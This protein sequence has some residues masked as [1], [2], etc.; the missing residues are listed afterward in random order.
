M[1]LLGEREHGR[2]VRWGSATTA[3]FLVVASL[4]QS[5]RCSQHVNH[6]QHGFGAGIA[7]VHGTVG[8]GDSELDGGAA[9]ARK[10]ARGV[11]DSGTP[12]GGMRAARHGSAVVGSLTHRVERG[13]R[14]RLRGG[15]AQV[16]V[17]HP[18]KRRSVCTQNACH[19]HRRERC[20]H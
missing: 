16:I 1:P 11:G 8:I 5:S 10:Q 2:R 15:D 6:A 3:L 18:R 20:S 17:P 19:L 7:R 4:P 9:G 14:L 13:G 12:A